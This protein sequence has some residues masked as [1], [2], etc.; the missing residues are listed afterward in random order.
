M[1]GRNKKQPIPIGIN[2]YKTM[3]VTNF[4]KN[5][6]GLEDK[7]DPPLYG[8]LFKEEDEYIVPWSVTNPY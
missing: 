7:V 8:R 4:S 5:M 6:E 3:V 2:I 1:I